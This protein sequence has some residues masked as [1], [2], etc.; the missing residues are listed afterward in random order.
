M[1][2]VTEHCDM[3][4]FTRLHNI[5]KKKQ[6]HFI[7]GLYNIF[8]TLKLPLYDSRIHWSKYS[9]FNCEKIFSCETKQILN[10]KATILEH[11]IIATN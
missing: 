9:N 11:L 3:G 2:G 10:F 6:K 8:N 7:A 5:K 4:K 1:S